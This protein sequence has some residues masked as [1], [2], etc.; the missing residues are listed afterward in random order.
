MKR[1]G[2]SDIDLLDVGNEIQ[3]WGGI[4]SG[5]GRMFLVPLPDEDP[6]DVSNF[7]EVVDWQHGQGSSAPTPFVLVL[8]PSEMAAFLNQ[9]DVQDIK[10]PGKAI[11]R[12]SQRQVDQ[13]V[14]WR[15]FRRDEFRCRYCGRDD[16]PLT[17]DHVD[18]WEDGG[19]TVPENLLSACR[20][21][22]KL[23]GSTAYAQWITSKEYLGVAANLSKEAFER[24]ILIMASLSS[25]VGLRT[26]ARS[27]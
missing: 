24:N 7:Q 17:V 2:L 5:K 25:L 12:K 26:K 27:R 18:L 3:M 4:W 23:R 22:N 9:S 21:C 16:V 10:G 19:A 11:L 1:I 6:N 13:H 8:T 20:R 15:V 14:S